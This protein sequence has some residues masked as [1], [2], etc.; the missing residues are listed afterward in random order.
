MDVPCFAMSCQFV[1][2]VFRAIFAVPIVGISIESILV[3][4][5]P[6]RFCH[7]QVGSSQVAKVFV[8]ISLFACAISASDVPCRFH[9]VLPYVPTCGSGVSRPIWPF[10]SMPIFCRFCL[11]V[12]LWFC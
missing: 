6:S 5:L 12:W 2:P 1:A 7:V 4:D 3:L 8:I 9:L 11:V 10:A